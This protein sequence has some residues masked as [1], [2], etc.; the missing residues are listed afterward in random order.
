MRRQIWNLTE[1]SGGCPLG[2]PELMAEAMAKHRGLADEYADILVSYII[3][4]GNFLEFIPLQRGA[5][6]GIGRLAEVYPELV[7]DAVPHLNELMK[8]DDDSARE[9]ACLAL[10]KLD[11]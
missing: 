9:L 2:S 4:E 10:G 5:V 6:W 11:V 1:E 3:P 7:R 8:S